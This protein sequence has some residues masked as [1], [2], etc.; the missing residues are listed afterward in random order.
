MFNIVKDFISVRKQNNPDPLSQLK[1][2]HPDI[3]LQ[4]IDFILREENDLASIT[5]KSRPKR[6]SKRAKNNQEKTTATSMLS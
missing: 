4:N 6:P 2:L 5:A 1:A 3:E